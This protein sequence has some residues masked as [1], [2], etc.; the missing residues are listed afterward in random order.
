MRLVCKRSRSSLGCPA[1]HFEHAPPHAQAR[2]SVGSGVL[3]T[4]SATRS[5]SCSYSSPGLLTA[6]F[7]CITPAMGDL[8][9]IRTRSWPKRGDVVPVNM[10]FRP[11][12]LT[13]EALADA[14]GSL[15][16]GFAA[17]VRIAT[18][19]TPELID[20]SPHGAR[21][22]DRGADIDHRQRRIGMHDAVRRH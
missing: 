1:L 5:A 6:S 19:S 11:A 17:K 4:C 18:R 10:R 21:H 14:G 16:F 22:G 9:G 13:V 2:W 3:I 20:L 7:V 8:A 12:L 15:V